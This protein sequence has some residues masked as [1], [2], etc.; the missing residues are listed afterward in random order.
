MVFSAHPDD[1][2]GTFGATLCHYTVCRQLPVILVAVTSGDAGGA[3]MGLIRED[4][5]R[6]AVWTY[7]MRHEPIFTHF[8]DCCWGYGDLAMCWD[9]WGGQ[10]HVVGVFTQLIRQYRPDV[11]MC[12]DL[13]NGEYGHPN[14]MASGIAAAEAYFA[15]ADP[16]R[17]PEQLT[18]LNTWQA[19]KCYVHLHP[20]NPVTH[21][22]NIPCDELGGQTPQN[23]TTDG[24]HCHVSQGGGNFTCSASDDY[25][26]YGTTVGVDTQPNDFMQNIDLSYYFDIP[27][28]PEN[29]T[30]NVVSEGE[31]ALSWDD[32]S[33]D[34]DGFVIQRKPYQGIGYMRTDIVILPPN[35]TSYIDTDS[36]HGQILYTYRVG[37]FIE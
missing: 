30:A 33:D 27:N 29:L 32:M 19:K 25:G 35:T 31:I 21:W 10:D 26:L 1:E 28:A 14:H 6:C 12:H 34:E 9:I 15:A 20:T 18:T 2:G 5:L 13:I 23:V 3:H 37:A 4:E 8:Q 16:T 24:L 17:Y 11:V 22:W 36:I 7:G